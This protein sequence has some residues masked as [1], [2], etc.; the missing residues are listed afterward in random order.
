LSDLGER[1]AA[2]ARSYLAVPYHHAGRGRFGLDCVGL[3]AVVAHDLGITTFDDLNYQPEPDPAYLTATLERFAA[4]YWDRDT[5][6]ERLRMGL[7]DGDLLQFEILG[8]ARHCGIYARDERGEGTVI[9]TYQAAGKVVEHLFDIHWQ[10]RLW[11][12]YRLREQE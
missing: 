1:F 5:P 12:A 3:L 4:R 8:S 9:H 2:Q 11:A 7:W 10:R 6:A